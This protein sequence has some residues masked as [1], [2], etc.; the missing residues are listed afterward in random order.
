[1][2]K[3][4]KRKNEGKGD[5]LFQL[6]LFHVFFGVLHIVGCI[7]RLAG[8]GGLDILGGDAAPDL[9]RGYLGA[10]QHKGAG[11]DDGTLPHLAVVEDGGTHAYEGTVADGAG[12]EGDVVAYGDVA[13]YTRGADVVGHVYAGAVLHVGAVADGDGGHVAAHHGVEPHRALVA[14]RHIAHQRGVL[15]EVAALPQRG[16]LPL[17]DLISAISKKKGP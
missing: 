11:G 3:Q 15:A 10:L 2:Y 4:L 7:I 8:A 9:V 13:A 17:Y 14:Q 1:M 6:Q 12:M 16:D 5:R